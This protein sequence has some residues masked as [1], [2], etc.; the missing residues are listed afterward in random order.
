[1]HSTLDPPPPPSPMRPYLLVLDVTSDITSIFPN[2]TTSAPPTLLGPLPDH[3][4]PPTLG[5][6][7]SQALI[8]SFSA[9][10]PSY[11]KD[12]RQG[13]IFIQWFDFSPSSMSQSQRTDHGLAGSKENIDFTTGTT[14]LFHGTLHLYRPSHPLVDERNSSGEIKGDGC[15][16]GKE[17]STCTLVCLIAIPAQLTPADLLTFLSPSLHAIQHIR[18][19]HDPSPHRYMALCALTTPETATEFIQRH[20]GQP[21]SELDPEICHALPISSVS[22]RYHPEDQKDQGIGKKLNDTDTPNE[23]LHG[24]PTLVATTTI[25]GSDDPDKEKKGEDE[26]TGQ[27][28]ARIITRPAPPFIAPLLLDP[29]QM[30]DLRGASSSSTTD[31]FPTTEASTTLAS[32]TELPLCPVCL[33]RMDATVTGLLTIACNHT[34]HCRC[35]LRWESA[36]C[37]VCR[38]S[39]LDSQPRLDGPEASYPSSGLPVPQCEECGTQDSLWICLVCG[40]LGCGRYGEAHAWQHYKESGHVYAQ[41]VETQRVWDYVGDGYVHRLLQNRTDG[42][43]VE[44]PPTARNLRSLGQDSQADPVYGMWGG[45]ETGE[46]ADKVDAM[47]FEYTSLLS[48]QLETQREYYEGLINDMEQRWAEEEDRRA[49]ESRSRDGNEMR[50]KE[51]Y[52]D[53]EKELTSQVETLKREVEAQSQKLVSAQTKNRTLESLVRAMQREM[54]EEREMDQGF[55]RNHEELKAEVARKSEQIDDLT[56][57]VHD[58]MIYMET[59]DRVERGGLSHVDLDAPVELRSTA[60]SSSGKGKGKGKK[61]G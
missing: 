29:L 14:P 35:M 18:L 50:L 49:Q 22:I 48:A 27:D 38:F 24:P 20:N 61:R 31:A 52:R 45:Q 46:A 3:P 8:D 4:I 37:P 40:H 26:G 42:K 58:L 47:A 53:R 54:A 1:M 10:Y 16:L 6:Q 56:E 28:E 39:H 11:P 34:F 32:I 59:R 33:E 13:V 9:S 5:S 55:R 2:H 43:L 12:H 30:D 36:K 19:L 57:Q 21:F 44:L 60:S 23:S 15:T 51:A 7:R 17:K 25:T 41:E